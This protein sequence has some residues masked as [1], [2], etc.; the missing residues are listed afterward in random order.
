MVLITLAADKFHLSLTTATDVSLLFWLSFS[1][2]ENPTIYLT[3]LVSLIATMYMVAT[4][5]ISFHLGIELHLSFLLQVACK[6]G[7]MDCV[8]NQKSNSI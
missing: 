7:A 6:V 5:R 1:M 4:Q 3:G 8:Q 2:T